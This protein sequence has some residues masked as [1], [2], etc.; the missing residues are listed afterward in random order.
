[1]VPLL[2][3][4]F[5]ETAELVL[6]LNAKSHFNATPLP[7]TAHSDWLEMARHALGDAISAALTAGGG[8]A[9]TK[10]VKPAKREPAPKSMD[11][12]CAARVAGPRG[13]ASQPITGGGGSAVAAP[14]RP[15]PAAKKGADAPKTGS[16]KKS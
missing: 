9:A 16:G 6:D 2:R 3:N 10:P 4:T 5:K 1:M 11:D 14:Q 12:S 13:A 8:A 7:R 15:T